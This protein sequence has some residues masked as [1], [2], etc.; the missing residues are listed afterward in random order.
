MKNT[1]LA[2]IPW[3]QQ[4]TR[5]E[6][7][8]GLTFSERH[9]HAVS[10]KKKNKQWFVDNTTD[11]DIVENQ[12]IAK[13]LEAVVTSVTRG[14]S[15][16]HVLLPAKFYQAVQVEKPELEE[17]EII[18]SLPWTVKELVQIKPQ[19]MVV[20][21]IDYAIDAPNQGKKI[22]AYICDKT[23]LQPI[24]DA[25]QGSEQAHLQSLGIKELA[26]TNMLPND[27]VARMVVFQE[28]GQEPRVL[29]VRDGLLLLSRQLRGF[30]ALEQSADEHTIEQ[31]AETLGLEI[32]RSLD[33]FESQ[34]KQPPVKDVA[35]YCTYNT[36]LLIDKLKTTQFLPVSEFKPVMD[37]ADTVAPQYY[38]ALSAA[39]FAALEEA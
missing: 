32:Q 12:P 39:Y 15:A 11:S 19:N 35:L 8:V 17:Q 23:K 9:I 3:L 2:R 5:V 27:G 34:L 7:V 24:V 38:L 20:D 28:A 1:W 31:L 29:I 22:T 25:F 6:S 16:V 4:Q 26:V 18:Q 10:L 33:F 13:Q 36:E 37:L 14:A 30:K 21:Y